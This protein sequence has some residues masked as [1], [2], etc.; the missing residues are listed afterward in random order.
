MLL[1]LACNQI[2]GEGHRCSQ[3]GNP[4]NS[5]ASTFPDRPERSPSP[6]KKSGSGLSHLGGLVV[7]A[8]IVIAAWSMSQCSRSSNL[9]ST[10]TQ[11]QSSQ[12]LRAKRHG[13][14]AF[15]GPVIVNLGVAGAALNLAA[16]AAQSGDMVSAQQA[17]S[18]AAKY[19]DA[20]SKASLNNAPDDDAWQGIGSDLYSASNS[21]KKAIQ[22]MRDGLAT[23]LGGHPKCTTCGQLKMYQG[24]V[25]T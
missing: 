13:A 5:G 22:E 14:Q 16:Q 25:A 9:N 15:W 20:A 7:M 18:A 8:L 19:A 24:S 6:E 21:Y 10:E 11:P 1:C 4:L 2:S 12:D 23:D 17:L 3:C